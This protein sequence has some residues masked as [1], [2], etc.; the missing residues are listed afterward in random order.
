MNGNETIK[1]LGN[2]ALTK[3]AGLCRRVLSLNKKLCSTL[4]P[5]TQV[6]KW[7]PANAGDNPAMGYRLIQIQG[8]VGGWGGGEGSS[9]T[10]I[11]CFMLQKT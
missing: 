11:S 9:N 4:S 6:Y 1:K 8:G 10:T 3:N 2:K 5:S 7:V